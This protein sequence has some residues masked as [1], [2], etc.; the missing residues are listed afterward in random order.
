MHVAQLSSRFDRF[1]NNSFSGVLLVSLSDSSQPA[2]Q[3]GIVSVISDTI[4]AVKRSV[5]GEEYSN[6]LLGDFL[7]LS[8]A[9]FYAAYVT[10]LK[11]RIRQESRINMQLFFGFV[12]LLN[13]LF[14]WPLGLI[15][16]LTGAETFELPSSGK[17]TGG[18]LVNVR[19]VHTNMDD[20][21][22]TFYPR[23]LSH[24][25]ATSFMSS[26]C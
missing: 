26:P 21:A 19:R 25:Q 18:L 23:C 16:H 7:A 13:I 14:L 9:M 22:E 2:N 12:G 5:H 11:V 17:A 4:S 1:L 15:L 20:D 3:R 10:L 24:C 6:P 8:S